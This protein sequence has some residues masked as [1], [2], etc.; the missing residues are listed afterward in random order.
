MKKLLL[1][2]ISL[3]LSSYGFSQN[4]VKIIDSLK[5]ELSKNPS[6]SLKIKVYSDLCWY[7]RTIS[8]DSAF[9]Y[10]NLALKL[11]QKTNNRVG[12]AQAHNDIG[13]LY[14]GLADYGQA[15]Q[16]YNLA[17]K[18]RK[19]LQDTLGIASVYNKIGL[20][21]QNTFQL[22][23]AIVYNTK[24]LE[25]YEQKNHLKYAS[26][27]KGNIANIYRGLKQYDKALKTHLEITE[28]AKEIEDFP[29][30]TRSYNNIAN[31]YL[32]MHDT[33]NSIKY[34]K[35]GIDV[36][37]AN[38]LNNELG[39]LYNNYG[40]FLSSTGQI[41][42]AIDYT[43]KSLLIRREIKDNHGITS[44][45]LNLGDLYLKIG[46]YKIAKKYLDEGI[47]LAEQYKANELRVN[48][49]NNL[50]YYF[51]YNKESDSVKF[52]QNKYKQIEDSIF[53]NR[54]TKEVAEVQEKYNANEREKQILTQRAEIAEKE[55]DLSQKNSFI[56]G[57]VGLAVVLSLLGFLVYNQQKLKNRQ[58]KKESE[59]KE[60]LVKIETQN[61]LQDQRLRISRDLHDN[62]GAQ[63]TFI[64]SSLDNLKYGFKLPDNLN[65][66]LKYISEFTTSTIYELRDTIWAMNKSE[67]SFEDLQARISNFIEKADKASDNIAFNFTIDDK[68]KNSKVF[69]SVQGMSIYRI[70]QEAINNALK[71]ADATQI[72]VDFSLSEGVFQMTVTDNG[73][74]FD[75]SKI[76]YG[77]GLNNMKKRAHELESEFEIISTI[78]KGTTIRVF[79]LINT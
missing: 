12:E 19:K 29:L 78:N 68:L 8:T 28:K 62:I 26:A 48:G 72:D 59:L 40:S 75:V 22:D 21:Y 69:T 35:Q 4:P 53:N 71:Y 25:I 49:Y 57:L 3:F 39:A 27:L 37:I 15:M 66:K 34:F 20:C 51:A 67:I 18:I 6:D 38:N 44:S 73:T 31:A 52:Y 64:I 7:Y 9:T 77:N 2:L 45:S 5:I 16:E 58:L 43:L 79:K 63:L 65:D 74:G 76:E 41:P 61:K 55:R 14:Y 70:I 23:S 46:E 32:H 24:A 1:I 10:G 33:I 54:I 60:A 36:A 50:S 56:L 30:L 13:I 47:V 11:S 42:E 17:L